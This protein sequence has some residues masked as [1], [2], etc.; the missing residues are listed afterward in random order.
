MDSDSVTETQIFS[1]ASISRIGNIVGFSVAAIA[2]LTLLL[3]ACLRLEQYGEDT[4]YY[5]IP[6]AAL[7]GHIPISFTM[8]DLMY[9]RYLGFPPL[10]ELVQ[11]LLWR[12][13]GS[14]NAVSVTSYLAF[15]VFL[16]FCHRILRAR[17]WIVALIALCSPMVLIHLTIPYVDL[18]ANS[19]M[20]IEICA[21]VAQYYFDRSDDR[22][23]LL[24]GL[25]GLILAAWSKYQMVALC[26]VLFPLY[27]LLQM[28]HREGVAGRT[29]RLPAGAAI[30]LIAMLIASAPYVKNWAKYGNPFWPVALPV[31]ETL[32]PHKEAVYSQTQIH[33]ALRNTSGFRR[34]FLSLFEVYNGTVPMGERWNLDQGGWRMW[35]EKGFRMGGFWN[36]V[37]VVSNAALFLVLYLI[38]R[39]KGIIVSVWIVGFYCFIA[40]LPQS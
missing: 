35:H 9:Q 16:F 28:V 8:D 13:T 24:W 21:L 36:V 33:P 18:F 38:N 14:L 34:F 40:T 19:F 30:V 29:G 37:V 11:G 31:S 15:C 3:R 25:I 26:A 17:F 10:P 4:Y 32:F 5:H 22:A 27:F 6:F 39:K 23:L 12:I 7:Y 2:L 20:A 1:V